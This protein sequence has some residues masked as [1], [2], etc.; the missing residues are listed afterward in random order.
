MTVMT[1][2]QALTRSLAREGVEVVFAL[3]GVYQ[4]PS[5]RVVL[6]RHEQSAAYMADGYARTTGKPGW[7]WW[8]RARELSTPP[9]R[10]GPPSPRLH[11]CC[12]S[13]GKSKATTWGG[14]GALSMKW[15]SSWTF[16]NT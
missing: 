9:P 14:I 16:S 15:E 8:C 4:E 7:R 5:I 11:R 2:A 6:V 13:R 10:W 1:G 12:W 3:P